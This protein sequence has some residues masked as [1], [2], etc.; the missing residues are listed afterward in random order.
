MRTVLTIEKFLEYALTVV[1]FEMFS[2]PKKNAEANMRRWAMDI[3]RWTL[4]RACG[5]SDQEDMTP[6]KAALEM[7][8]RVSALTVEFSSLTNAKQARH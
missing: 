1:D 8:R 4:V 6:D 5:D 2:V 3:I 7:L